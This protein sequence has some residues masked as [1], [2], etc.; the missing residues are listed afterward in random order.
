MVGPGGSGKYLNLTEGYICGTSLARL[1]IMDPDVES[2]WLRR[3]LKHYRA[4]LGAITDQRDVKVL[5]ELIFAIAMRLHALEDRKLSRLWVLSES[6]VWR[7]AL[8]LITRHG[9]GAPEVAG[10][11]AD[12]LS[13]ENHSEGA[14]AWRRILH[15]TDEML[16]MKP[17]LGERV[18]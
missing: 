2:D 18:H 11:H 12:A 13:K 17:K 14:T 3:D 1:R 8:R 5:T 15:A 10:Q 6:D 16:R 9:V 4:E 7:A